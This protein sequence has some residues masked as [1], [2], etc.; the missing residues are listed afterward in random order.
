LWVQR[1][2]LGLAAEHP[3]AGDELCAIKRY[4]TIRTVALSC[5]SPPNAAFCARIGRGHLPAI[6]RIRK[7]RH[8]AEARSV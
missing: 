7:Q 4:V 1:L 5:C 2:K 6:P 8:A 3:I